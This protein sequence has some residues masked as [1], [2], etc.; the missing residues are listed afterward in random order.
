MINSIDYKSKNELLLK[1]LKL[2]KF[3]FSLGYSY[4]VVYF[5]TVIVSPVDPR[6]IL[7]WGGWCIYFSYAFAS[8]SHLQFAS[9][10][11]MHDTET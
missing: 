5:Q 8:V 11:D 1:L 3:N 4:T 7:C 10:S 6:I 2:L 9:M